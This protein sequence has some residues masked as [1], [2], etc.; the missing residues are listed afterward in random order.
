MQFMKTKLLFYL[1]QLSILPLA[2]GQ[3]ETRLDVNRINALISADG[4]MFL[5]ETAPG[6]NTI[7][8][9]DGDVIDFFLLSHAIWVSAIDPGEE[10]HMAAQTYRQSGTDFWAGPIADNYSADYD[11]RYARVWELQ[12]DSIDL[13][14]A[15][16]EDLGYEVPVSIAS[17]P[18]NGDVSNGEA[19]ILA[20]FFDYNNNGLYDP[21][22]GDYPIIRGDEAIYF[23]YNDVREEHTETNTDPI[24]IEIHGMAYA[25]NNSDL[26]SIQQT[27]YFNYAIINRSDVIYD[28]VRVASFDDISPFGFSS[29]AKWGT[30]VDLNMAYVYADELQPI[31]LAS[32][33][34]LLNESFN[35]V[36]FYNNDFSGQG[37]PTTAFGYNNYVNAAFADG[38]AL[39]FGGSGYGGVT[40]TNYHF[41]GDPFVDGSWNM[42]DEMIDA[43]KKIVASAGP[44]ILNPGD[45]ICLDYALSVAFQNEAIM[46]DSVL[47]EE[48]NLNAIIALQEQFMEIK[49][50]YESDITDCR[51]SYTM[52]S[53]STELISDDAAANI[54]VF[55]LPAK[56]FIMLVV[57][58]S[59]GVNQAQIIDMSGRVVAG[60]SGWQLNQLVDISHLAPGCYQMLLLSDKELYTETIIIQ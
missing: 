16:W 11:E 25:F 32:G 21:A 27:I 12:Q 56:D 10:L 2:L 60:S 55:P 54:R 49:S 47:S 30:N 38:T 42:M 22:S 40:P 44:F 6:S 20:P 36:I 33:I 13:H 17:W 35:S 14:I 7:T 51:I 23:M 8:S 57:P 48:F 31:N 45:T 52:N 29:T 59:L 37:N 4:C 28:D 41:D 1:L 18:G 19:A 46:V 3:Y 53:G 50:T 43:D 58:E 34:S 15:H 9:A 5:D 26:P 39:T 24:G